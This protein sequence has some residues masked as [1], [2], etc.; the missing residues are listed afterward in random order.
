MSVTFRELRCGCHRLLARISSTSSAKLEIK[1]P[2]CA[3]L[4]LYQASTGA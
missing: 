1:C 4:A 2:R 3:K